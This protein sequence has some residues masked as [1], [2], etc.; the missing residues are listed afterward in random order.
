MQQLIDRIVECVGRDRV[1]TGKAVRERAT[2]LWNGAPNPAAAILMPRS[3]EEVSAMLRLCHEARQTAIGR[4]YST[5]QPGR[6]S[7]NR[8]AARQAAP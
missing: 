6:A 5:S 1:L 2:S 3:T 7:P 4:R 8:T